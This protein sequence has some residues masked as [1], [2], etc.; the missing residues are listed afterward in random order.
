AEAQELLANDESDS[1]LLRGLEKSIDQSD[2]ESCEPVECNT[3]ND[4]NEPIRYIASINTPYSIVQETTE[5]VKVERKHLYSATANEIDEKKPELKDL[6]NHLEYAYLH[7]TGWRVCIDYRKLNNATRKDHFPFPFIDQMLE[8]LSTFQRCMTTIFHDMVE[9]IMEVFMDDFS[10]EEEVSDDEE[11]TQVKV[12]M[13]LADDELSVGKNHARNGEWI[14]ITMRKVNILLSMDEDTDWQ[15]YLKYINIDLKFV[16]DQRLNLLSK[17]NK[18]AFE[19]NKCRYDILVLKQAKL[20]VVTFQ[21]QNT[22]L[23]KLNHVLQEQVK[24][25]RKVNEKWLTSSKKVSQCMKNPFISASLD[26]DHEMIP[27]SKE[28]VKRHN[29]DNKL[30]NV[31]TER[32]LVPK[33][34]VVNECLKLTEAPT[35]P[36]S[37][38]ESGSEHLT[39]LPPLKNLHGASLSFEVMTLTYQ[40]HSPRER[41]GLGTMKQTNP[42]AQESL[43]KSVL[44]L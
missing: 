13:A 4:S 16:E 23:T 30:P 24:E 12:L 21:I 43:N 17:Y 1:F 6:P 5:P 37:S 9:D 35:G 7:V 22:E 25:K 31:N 3:D 14:D 26:Y 27:K 36:E 20:D 38:K 41:S 32:I 39:P 10:D 2:L 8:R 34:Q 40:D 11:M 15:T 42:E 44:D 29:L 19:L 28:W 18:I 33:S